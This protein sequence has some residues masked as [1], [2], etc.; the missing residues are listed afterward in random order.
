MIKYFQFFY[1]TAAKNFKHI[2][3]NVQKIIGNSK[4]MFGEI[5]NMIGFLNLG[6][7]IG[8]Y[9]KEVPISHTVNES[10]DKWILTRN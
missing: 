8:C 6:E 3:E 7:I 2:F 1:Q 9:L 4:N 5:K 10:A